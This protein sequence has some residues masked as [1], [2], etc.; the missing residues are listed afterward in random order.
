MFCSF[1]YKNPIFEEKN[2]PIVLIYIFDL[3]KQVIFNLP[4][5][6][7]TIMAPSKS[8]SNSK[9]KTIN[10]TVKVSKDELEEMKKDILDLK[11]KMKELSVAVGK[12]KSKASKAKAKGK[13]DP[14]APKRG[15]TAYN[16]YSKLMREEIMD[17]IRKEDENI[18][19]GDLNK[20]V[21][22]MIGSK[23]GDIDDEDKKKY[24]KMAKEDKVRYEKEKA[25][26]EERSSSQSEVEDESKS[27]EEDDVDDVEDDDYEE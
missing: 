9:S 18:T 25:K 22:K 4:S 17:E 23:W 13:K 20:M 14:D 16:F 26:Y 7:A 1:W 5:Y 19:P 21:M 6:Q 24:T 3:K 8:T 2:D 27:E 11:K 15:R 12:A 10:D